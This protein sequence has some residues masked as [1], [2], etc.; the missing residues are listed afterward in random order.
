MIQ[1][2]ADLPDRQLLEQLETQLQFEAFTH[3][4]ILTPTQV[5]S[6]IHTRC[7]Q[8]LCSIRNILSDERLDDAA[9]FERIERILEVF[10][11]LGSD[12]GSRHD[13]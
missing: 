2:T 10:E 4:R 9:C 7:Y 3:E 13:F 8:A 11:Q 12:G 6:I 1:N 5:E